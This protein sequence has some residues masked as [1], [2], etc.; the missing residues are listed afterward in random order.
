MNIPQKYRITDKGQHQP[1]KGLKP[2]VKVLLLALKIAEYE[3]PG[4]VQRGEL[5]AATA[6]P[7]ASF[8]RSWSYLLQEELVTRLKRPA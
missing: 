2:T 4:G 5:Q 6:L 3:R 7:E 8:D 1:M